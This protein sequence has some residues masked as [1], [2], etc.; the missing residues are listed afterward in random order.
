MTLNSPQILLASSSAYRRQLLEKLGLTFS[1]ESPEID[2][3]PHA[4]E[5]VREMVERL[6][7][8]KAQTLVKQQP[9]KI[10]IASDQSASLNNQAL[11][12]PGNFDR[13]FEQLKAQQG[14]VIC[15]YTGLVV[16]NPHNQTYL[17]ALDTTKVHFRELSDQ[18]IRNYLLAE[19]PYDCAGSFKSEGL[20]ITLF[21]KIENQD[22][23][24]LIGLPL[25]ELVNLLSQAGLSLPLDPRPLT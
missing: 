7:L 8:Q 15:F 16:Y 19:Q 11:G 13:A 4:Q 5:S 10:I 25:I 9:N 12:K 1:C 18:Q 14:Q 2:E 21:S 3:R 20:G 23:N 6:S 24:A 22:P 17:N